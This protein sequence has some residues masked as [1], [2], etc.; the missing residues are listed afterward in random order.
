MLVAVVPTIAKFD[1]CFQDY[2][3]WFIETYSFS[4]VILVLWQQEKKCDLLMESD[5]FFMNRV[6]IV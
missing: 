4:K 5:S 3:P 1:N 6:M 2:G